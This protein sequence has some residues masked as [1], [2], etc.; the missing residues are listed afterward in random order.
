MAREREE[1]PLESCS[2]RQGQL[3]FLRS[4]GSHDDLIYRRESDS[5]IRYD[6]VMTRHDTYT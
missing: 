1:G 4:D 5:M 3:V 6:I 2:G